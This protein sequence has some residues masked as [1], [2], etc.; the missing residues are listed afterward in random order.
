MFNGDNCCFGFLE[1]DRSEYINNNGIKIYH[2]YN[3]LITISGI[4]IENK[5][6]LYLYYVLQAHT[7]GRFLK[8]RGINYYF[9][10][11]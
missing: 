5:I 10:P 11:C 8:T 4:F 2:S 6:T 7:V 3:G 1:G 9:Y